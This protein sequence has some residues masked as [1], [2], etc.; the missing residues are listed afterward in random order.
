MPKRFVASTVILAA[1]LFSRPTHAQTAQPAKSGTA[2]DQKA[3]VDP[4]ELE[5]HLDGWGRSV[6]KPVPLESLK[7]T[8]APIH[9]IF[10]TWEP[11]PGWRNGVQATGAFNY[12][13]DGRH[14]APPFTPLGEQVWK[15]HKYGD[16]FGAAPL[17]EVND[18]F[19]MCDPIGFPRVD[20]HDLRAIQI[21]PAKGKLLV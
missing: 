3:P 13:S 11:A 19:E 2:K 17:G 10:G 9:D 20:L 5:D 8:P 16:G 7:S 6:P 18:P 14:P 4:S 1:L 12:P 15:T 21:V